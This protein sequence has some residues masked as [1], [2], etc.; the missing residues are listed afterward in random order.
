MVVLKKI[1]AATLVETLVASVI[2]VVVFMIASLSLNN[3]FKGTIQSNDSEIQNR[4]K[5]I[6]YLYKSKQIDI[7]FYENNEK[8][9]I[10]I[11]KQEG[12]IIL[13]AENKIALKT[14]QNTIGYDK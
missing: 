5:Q 2:I 12:E 8:W 13:L 7:P 4:I 14:F 6:T 11:E 3:I 1:R 9:D 10:S